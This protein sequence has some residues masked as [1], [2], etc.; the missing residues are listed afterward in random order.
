MADVRLVS[1][2]VQSDQ[3]S[4]VLPDGSMISST[5]TRCSPSAV[6]MNAVSTLSM[7]TSTVATPDSVTTSPSSVSRVE[8]SSPTSL[9][10]SHAPSRGRRRIAR[11]LG[12]IATGLTRCTD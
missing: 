3:V 12:S 2:L 8:E 11:M 5:E 1:V 9:S 4:T 10:R 7:S 6:I